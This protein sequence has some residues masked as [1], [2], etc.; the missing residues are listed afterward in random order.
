MQLCHL[1]RCRRICKSVV[2]VASLHPSLRGP[3]VFD[4][5]ELQQEAL[6]AQRWL[7]DHNDRGFNTLSSS[8]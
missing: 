7:D 3:F 4:N 6:N 8:S 2:K 5:E 1:E